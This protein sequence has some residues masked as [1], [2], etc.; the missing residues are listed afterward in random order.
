MTKHKIHN[1]R[2]INLG[3]SRNCCHCEKKNKTFYAKLNIHF[4]QENKQKEEE[5]EEE[6]QQQQNHSK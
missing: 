4:Q 1:Q 5:E 3:Y 2:I 6:Q